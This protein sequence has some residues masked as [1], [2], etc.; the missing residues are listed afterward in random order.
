M[1]DARAVADEPPRGGGGGASRIV[2]D[3][4]VELQGWNECDVA[5][6][7]AQTTFRSGVERM[8]AATT[9]AE[10]NHIRDEVHGF[11][12]RLALMMLALSMAGDVTKTTGERP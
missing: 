2:D 8:R 1:K 9:E 4:T 6:G 10:R 11:C 5:F 12:R 3:F 7:V